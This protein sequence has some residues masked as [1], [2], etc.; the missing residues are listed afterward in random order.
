VTLTAARRNEAART[1]S[2]GGPSAPRFAGSSLAARALRL[3]LA[4]RVRGPGAARTEAAWSASAP[5]VEPEEA[6]RRAPE[7]CGS[8][9]QERR[10][11]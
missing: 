6:L 2:I 11:R 7:E 10:R 1:R 8:R 4:G 3:S 9:C 5:V